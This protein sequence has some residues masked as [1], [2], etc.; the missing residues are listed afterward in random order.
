MLA[1][2][3]SY[4]GE[5]AVNNMFLTK[6]ESDYSAI[7]A[8]VFTSPEVSA[9]GLTEEQ[10]KSSGCD[11][12]AVTTHF[13]SI[14]MAHI[15]EETQGFAKVLVEVK[16]GRILGAS[17]IGIEA[18]E[19]INIF[20][21]LMKNNISIKNLRKTIFAHPSISEIIAEIAKSFD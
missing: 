18:T 2:V 4:E 16:T 19:L 10:L 7:P 17:I 8:S 3:A 11:Y 15:F 9:I 5:L 1:H 6:E 20:S 14:G 13:L 12:K 21:V